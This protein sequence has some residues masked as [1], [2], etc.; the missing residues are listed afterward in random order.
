MAQWPELDSISDKMVLVIGVALIGGYLYLMKQNKVETEVKQQDMSENEETLEETVPKG[1]VNQGYVCFVNSIVQCLLSTP[2]FAFRIQHRMEMMQL[3]QD[4]ALDW[5]KQSLSLIEK[6][7]NSNL[8]RLARELLLLMD[9]LAER[10]RG[11]AVDPENFLDVCSS[12]TDLVTA[13]HQQQQDAEEFLSFLMNGLHDVLNETPKS[14]NVVDVDR[15]EY[16]RHQC[17]QEVR[18]STSTNPESYSESVRRLA[19]I[20]WEEHSK[21]NQSVIAEM[22]SGQ[23]VRGT[24]CNQCQELSCTHQ[25]IRVL[26]LDVNA[27][28][29]GHPIQIENCLQQ[30]TLAETLVGDEQRF[31]TGACQMK[32]DWTTQILL[33]RLPPYL[34]IQ[35][36]RFEHKAWSSYG[37]KLHV[38][39]S[40]PF[41]NLNMTPYQFVRESTQPY[42]YDLYAICS[43]LGNTLDSGHYVAYTKQ[44]DGTWNKYNDEIVTPMTVEQVARETISTAYILFYKR[45]AELYDEA[46]V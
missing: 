38:E 2:E 24:I 26:Q 32:T 44:S 36:K 29:N 1:L 30:F 42:V 19:E 41:T 31:C 37:R 7:R 11:K 13:E 16:V 12:C 3:E 27:A 5:R 6:K 40:F 35:L 39:L 33:Q 9:K 43:H 4:E 14:I 46:D 18:R 20:E 45:S 15:A 8:N 21:S 34:I 10:D 22:F 17:A 25:E 28:P 23:M